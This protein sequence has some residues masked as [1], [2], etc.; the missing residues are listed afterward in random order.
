M[1]LLTSNKGGPDQCMQVQADLGFC[2]KI[3]FSRSSSDIIDFDRNTWKDDLLPSYA[4]KS[5]K[6]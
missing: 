6:S 1:I 4:Y 2:H 5:V 3:Y